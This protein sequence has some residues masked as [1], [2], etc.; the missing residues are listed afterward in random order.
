MLLKMKM[1]HKWK[2]NHLRKGAIRQQISRQFRNIPVLCVVWYLGGLLLF[3]AIAVFDTPGWDKCYYVWQKTC[4]CLFLFS[5]YRLLPSFRKPLLPIIIYSIIRLCFQIIGIFRET[6]QND[7]YIVTTL[8][9][10][11]LSITIA[12]TVKQQ[13]NEW[14][15]K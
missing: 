15:Q 2:M 14:K 12:L 4:D 7:K 9:L 1:L 11:A 6:D 8:F 3:N 10:S 5:L 13:I